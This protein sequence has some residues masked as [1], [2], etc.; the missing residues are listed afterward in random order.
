MQ[1]PRHFRR[2]SVTHHKAVKQISEY[3]VWNSNLVACESVDVPILRHLAATCVLSH[4]I[5]TCVSESLSAMLRYQLRF[6]S[7]ISRSLT[8]TLT[9]AYNINDV[10]CNDKDSIISQIGFVQ[11]SAFHI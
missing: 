6:G 10:W 8:N 5:S 11:K 4:Y 7:E 2:A 1:A 9:K 3:T